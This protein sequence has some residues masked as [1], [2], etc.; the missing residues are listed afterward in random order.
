MLAHM[1]GRQGH[2]VATATPGDEALDR[3]TA[4]AFDLVITDVAMGT[5]MNGWDL[6]AA[7]RQ[8]WPTTRVVLATGWGAAI[9]PVEAHTRGV[10]GVLHKPYRIDDLRRAIEALGRV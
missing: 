6:A 4:E 3:L 5:G 8:R 2:A 10:A 1:L 7:V 9:D